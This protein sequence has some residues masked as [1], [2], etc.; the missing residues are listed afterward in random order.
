MNRSA[1]NVFLGLAT[2]CLAAVTAEAGSM[3]TYLT[4]AAR[5]D[6][7]FNPLPLMLD[8]IGVV[9]N[10]Y[11]GLYQIDIS[12]TAANSPGDKGWANT[13]F[14]LGAGSN[15]AGSNLALNQSD[16]YIANTNTL[17]TNGPNPGGVKPVYARNTDTGDPTDLQA[18]LASIESANITTT[19]FDTRNNLGTALAPFGAFNS[20]DPGSYIGSFFVDWNGVSTGKVVLRNQQYSFTRSDNTFG[21]T[22]TGDGASATFGYLDQVPPPD[23]PEP[24]TLTLA[25]LA[26][27]GLITFTRGRK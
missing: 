15:L 1:V 7:A 25:G 2:L 9:Q 13:L 18:V 12:F 22:Q 24:G 14:D 26:L 4:V 11:P 10:G 17:D 19:A 21:P 23:T 16:G 20:P 27:A 3:K 8:S 6:N 5:Y